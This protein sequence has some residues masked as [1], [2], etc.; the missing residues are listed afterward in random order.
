MGVGQITMSG[1]EYVVAVGAVDDGLVME[2]LRYANEIRPSKA[3][4]DDL[5]DIELDEEMVGLA[6]ELIKK[7]SSPF[8]PD[9][10]KDRYAVALKAMIDEKAKG[11]HIVTK[12][13]GEAPPTN[14]VDL[15]AALR[16]S[17]KASAAKPEQAPKG[18]PARK[19]A[20]A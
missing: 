9:K 10:Y 1:R 20:R 11:H 12:P 16:N 17:L 8:G 6:S 19:T 4:F 3:Y 14:V 7:K 5:P 15:M 18:K 2:I 13:E